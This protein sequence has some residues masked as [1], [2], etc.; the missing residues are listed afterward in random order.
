MNTVY[1]EHSISP[2][3]LNT[4]LLYTYFNDSHVISILH[5]IILSTN[6]LSIT[7]YTNVLHSFQDGNIPSACIIWY[8]LEFI[9]FVSVF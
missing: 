4:P 5:Y 3:C 2:T 1:H 7:A 6:A 8:K 9:N